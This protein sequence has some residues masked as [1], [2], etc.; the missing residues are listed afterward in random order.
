MLPISCRQP[1]R[2]RAA[3]SCVESQSQ[4][5]AVMTWWKC[6]HSGCPRTWTI[7]KR[8]RAPSATATP[9]GGKRC[10]CFGFGDRC[11]EFTEQLLT[12]AMELDH[13]MAMAMLSEIA[14]HHG[15]KEI[16]QQ[17]GKKL[18]EMKVRS[19]DSWTYCRLPV[20]QI[21]RKLLKYKLDWNGVR[22]RCFT[23][24]TAIGI[25]VGYKSLTPRQARRT[26]DELKNP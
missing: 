9:T 22:P 6:R 7:K 19:T 14:M 18:Q 1:M 20:R 21:T 17:L 24:W 26:V 4:T 3:G 11:T 23:A 5:S 16:T 2:F 10:R 8:R 25:P 13:W 15:N 12:K